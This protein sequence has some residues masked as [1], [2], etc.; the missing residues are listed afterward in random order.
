LAIVA[1]GTKNAGDL[2]RGQTR[3]RAKRQR[4]AAFERKRRVTARE[5]EAQAVIR[6]PALVVLVHGQVRVV[7]WFGGNREVGGGSQ[8]LFLHPLVAQAVYR[9]IARDR[10]QPRARLSGHAIARPSPDRLGERLLR[11]VL[12]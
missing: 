8:A 1:S 5:H 6:D 4:D 2:G 7:G 11:T 3:E 10:R 9:P 12:G